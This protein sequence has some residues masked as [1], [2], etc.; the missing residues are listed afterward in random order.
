MSAFHP[1]ADIRSLSQ[2]NL[3]SALLMQGIDVKP[4]FSLPVHGNRK[5]RGM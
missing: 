2:H 1:K 5:I 3:H 4:N